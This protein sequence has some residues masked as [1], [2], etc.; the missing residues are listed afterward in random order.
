M[1]KYLLFVSDSALS[2]FSPTVT[3]NACESLD[4]YDFWRPLSQVN[5]MAGPGI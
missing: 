2:I 3:P 4:S 1:S 5:D